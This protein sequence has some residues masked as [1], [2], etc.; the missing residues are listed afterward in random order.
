MINNKCDIVLVIKVIPIGTQ[1][2]CLHLSNVLAVINLGGKK[3]VSIFHKSG[4]FAKNF[5][6]NYRSGDLN[7]QYSVDA[8]SVE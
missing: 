8:R 7:V 4:T 3:S 2:M 1:N 5:H 6:L